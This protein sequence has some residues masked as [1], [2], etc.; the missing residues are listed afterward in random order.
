MAP[1][2]RVV[3]ELAGPLLAR[4]GFS[5]IFVDFPGKMATLDKLF[6]TFQE[7]VDDTGNKVTVVGVG[8]VG[9]AAVFSMLTQV[10]IYFKKKQVRNRINAVIYLSKRC[11]YLL[12]WMDAC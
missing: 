5:R 2:A 7:K 3:K 6:Q 4:K 12:E 9:M 10:R 8:Q 1:I 11:R